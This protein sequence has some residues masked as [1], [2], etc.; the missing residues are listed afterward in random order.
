MIER[1]TKNNLWYFLIFNIIGFGLFASWWFE[2]TVSRGWWDT[3]DASVFYFLNGSLSE[4]YYW[5][6]FWSAANYRASD[7][8]PALYLLGLYGY[9]TF[10]DDSSERA[11]YIAVFIMIA[12]FT[13]SVI[14]F[15][16]IF[17]S[18]DRVSPSLVLEPVYRLRELIPW[19]DAKDAS[20]GSFP[21]DHALVLYLWTGYIWFY[22]GWRYGLFTFMLSFLFLLPRLVSGAH[23][24]TDDIIGGGA[25]A[26]VSIGWLF[27]TP[28]QR[29]LMKLLMPVATRL[30]GFI[31]WCAG[32]VGVKS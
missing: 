20:R 4:G 27:F 6:L 10:S 17:I 13:P 19:I 25:V 3:L 29:I 26:L 18:T 2:G 11:K 15:V 14:E 21:S 24:L 7:L 8:V 31:N 32:L 9:L 28:A 16:K 1:T 23:W 22:A 12:I 5:Q 30:S